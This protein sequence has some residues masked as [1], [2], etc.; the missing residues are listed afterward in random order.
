MTGFIFIPGTQIIEEP[1]I[2]KPRASP[3]P[4]YW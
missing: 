1:E 3:Q 4:G 2:M